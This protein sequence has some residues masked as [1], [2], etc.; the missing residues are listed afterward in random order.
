[1][2]F[3]V[4]YGCVMVAFEDKLDI[5]IFEQNHEVFSIFMKNI[6]NDLV[7]IRFDTFADLL[8]SKDLP[9]EQLD[10]LD[11]LVESIT[12]QSWILPAVYR[13]FIS[14]IIWFKPPWAHEFQDGKH[15][16]QVGKCQQ[17]GLLKVASTYPYFTSNCVYSSVEKLSNV[18]IV[19][20][21]V[22][23]IG[24]AKNFSLNSTET[25][26]QI[27]DH[28]SGSESLD[29][30]NRKKIKT[31]SSSDFNHKDSSA[32]YQRTYPFDINVIRQILENKRFILDFD[33]SFFST[34]DPIR[35]QFDENEYEILRYVY[36]RVVH[37]TS[38]VEIQ[39]YISAR[40]T[41][42]DQI[43]TFMEEY[44]TEPK[45]EQPI[46]IENPYLTALIAVI[47]YKKMNWKT[48]HH[49]AMHLADTRPPNHISSEEMIIYLLEGASKILQ[50]LKK[51]PIYITIS[52]CVNDGFC[53]SDQSD[54][55][56][57]YVEKKLRKLY[58][59][60][61]TKGKSLVTADDEE[62]EDDD[63]EP[64]ETK[65]QKTN[66]SMDD[67]RIPTT[68]TNP[69]SPSNEATN[70]SV[71]PKPT[72]SEETTNPTSTNA[73]SSPSTSSTAHPSTG[74][75]N[76]AISPSSLSEG[77]PILD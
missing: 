57:R 10:G 33:L 44:L 5:E 68:S 70:L 45:A 51:D 36:T 47:R 69:I 4:L 55:I 25:T 67:D 41:A 62:E 37:D 61:Q 31:S 54:L 72:I 17:T 9:A 23:T 39:R 35:R 11:R 28:D 27:F 59:I 24:L 29:T 53:S 43:K 12:N 46:M 49:Y 3:V 20:V 13:G 40:E 6:G 56:Q 64:G 18:Q 30:D 74:D 71:K 26:G 42:L 8:V 73:K 14:K 16:I 76:K 75:M 52:R 15:Q 77:S 1:M 32:N 50:A 38:D 65:E 48:I 21:F 2:S 66:V 60:N 7:L 63:T 58:K 22:L 34:D 19:D